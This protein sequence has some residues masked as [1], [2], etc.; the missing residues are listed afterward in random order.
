VIALLAF[1]VQADSDSCSTLAE[2]ES[3]CA[4]ETPG[5]SALP[6]TGQAPC[7]CYL[8]T[9]TASVSTI[10]W[11]PS[12]YDG[13][14]DGCLSYYKTADPG[15]LTSI[16]LQPSDIPSVLNPCKRVGDL[17]PCL[18]LEYLQA[19]CE[20]ETPGFNTITASSVAASCLC[21]SGTK[22]SP[23]TFDDILN[24]CRRYQKTNVP[25]AMTLPL[26]TDNPCQTLGNVRATTTGASPI[27][28]IT[29]PA[30]ASPTSSQASATAIAS[31]TSEGSLFSIQTQ[32]S[33]SS[34]GTGDLVFPSSTSENFATLT[35]MPGFAACSTIISINQN[36]NKETP[37]FS[38]LSGASSQASCL[39][40][41][42]SQWTPKT[43]DSAWSSCA[44]FLSVS[45]F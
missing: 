31:G 13:Y 18:E 32:T 16:G 38:L 42:G 2:I 29:T 5:F 44:S 23:K 21:Y 37:G 36:C 22:W 39:C 24:S 11:N 19:S 25:A 8:A 15:F 45:P 4:G 40:Y 27:T 6:L 12:F 41:S 30:I 10:S 28:S 9:G 26:E 1:P 3:F 43:Y 7:Y 17:V 20:I 33:L 34:T 35:T 14:F